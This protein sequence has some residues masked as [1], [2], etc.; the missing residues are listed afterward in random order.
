ME[1]QLFCCKC[2]IAKASNW[3]QACQGYTNTEEIVVGIASYR[4]AQFI[5]GLFH[6]EDPFRYK[7][8]LDEEFGKYKLYQYGTRYHR[9][10]GKIH[11]ITIGREDKYFEVFF[12]CKA[13]TPKA[14]IQPTE[15]EE[16]S[17]EEEV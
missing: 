2:N 10:H 5:K 16:P 15:Y 12:P 14:I 1:I 13:I 4:G 9:G 6:E 17:Q 7:F 11:Y 3:C 8:E